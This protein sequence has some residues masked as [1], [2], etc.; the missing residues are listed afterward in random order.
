MKF[1]IALALFG[2]AIASP[3]PHA[4]RECDSI[5]SQADPSVLAQV[6][7]ICQQRGCNDR[8]LLATFETLWI[9]THGNNLPCGDQDSLGVF[10]QRPSQ[11]WGSPAQLMDVTYSTNAYLDL[12]IP[13][14]AANPD[15]APG[16]IA[17]TVQRSDYP[18]RYQQVEGVARGLIAQV[19][20]A[21][22]AS[23]AAS[24]CSSTYT[25]VAGDICSV[26]AQNY[27]ISV[28][29][30]LSMNPSIDARCS[31]LQIGTAYCV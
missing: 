1:F 12:C 18:D 9:E 23:Q 31:N 22:H 5:P 17:Q 15:T 6:Y 4:K 3:L 14:E 7:S 21:V 27:D 20:G 19:Q 29:Q 24:V 11:G 25:P 8:V 2:V 28:D 13:T 16:V 30:F 10:Q 26:I